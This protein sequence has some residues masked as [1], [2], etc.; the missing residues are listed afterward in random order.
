LRNTRAV[1]I[2][3]MRG[4]LFVLRGR[5]DGMSVAALRFLIYVDRRSVSVQR[6]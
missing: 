2:R 3:M 1:V 5:N 4:V 6:N